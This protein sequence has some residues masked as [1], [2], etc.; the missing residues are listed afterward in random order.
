VPPAGETNNVGGGRATTALNVLEAQG[1]ANFTDFRPDG[2]MFTALVNDGGQRF[3][4]VINPDT[5]QISRQ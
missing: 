2:S 4:V 1:Y 3:R 5:G